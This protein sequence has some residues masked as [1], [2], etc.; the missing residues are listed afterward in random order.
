MHGSRSSAAWSNRPTATEMTVMKLRIGS[1]RSALARAQ[2]Q[3]LIETLVRLRPDVQPEW[4]WITTTGDRVRDRPLDAVGGKGLFLK[5]IEQALL[6][7]QI[8]V[9]IHS[10]KDIPAQLPDGLEL[11]ATPRRASPYDVLLSR[12]PVEASQKLTVGTGSRRRGFQLTQLFPRARIEPLRGNVDTRIG[13]VREG[14]LDAVVLAEAGLQRLG[15]EWDGAALRLETMLPA[16]AQGTLA[17]EARASR[18]D[19]RE[20]FRVVH[21]P[22]TERTFRAE[23]ATL[24]AIDGDCFTP[25]AAFAQQFDDGR[26]VLDAAL[27]DDGGQ[28]RGRVRVEGNDPEALGATAGGRLLRQP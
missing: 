8:D 21:D 6:A 15:I 19:L 12:N 2:A 4:V 7:D 23:R 26:L 5:E 24:A 18:E 22:E 28:L 14:R 16:V 27:W 10:G 20:L 9:A 25:F 11:I 13:H 1:R 3:A 17:V